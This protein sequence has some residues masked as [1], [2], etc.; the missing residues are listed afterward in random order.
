MPLDGNTFKH[1]TTASTALTASSHMHTHSA[2]K[3]YEIHHLSL[4]LTTHT[5]TWYPNGVPLKH[6]TITLH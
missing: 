3:L 1:F 4:L 2:I 6:T 5:D